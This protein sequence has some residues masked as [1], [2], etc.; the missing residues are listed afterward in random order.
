[1]RAQVLVTPPTD[2]FAHTESRE[3]FAHAPILPTKLAER[4][5]ALYLSDPDDAASQWA[6]PARASDLSDLPPALVITMEVDPLRDEGEDYARA[7]AAAGV[8]TVCRRF[9]GLFHATF[10]F[11][12]T[13][14]RAAEI[15]DAIANFLAPLL[16]TDKLQPIEHVG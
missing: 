5:G 3:V 4:M 8:S 15:Q 10:S 1:M 9:N 2:Y 14:P 11:S 16:A 7:L 13:I 12:G 6:A